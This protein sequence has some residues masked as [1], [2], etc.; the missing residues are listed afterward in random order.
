MS[1]ESSTAQD[2]LIRAE[3]E[4]VLARNVGIQPSEAEIQ[5]LTRNVPAYQRAMLRVRHLPLQHEEAATPPTG[6]PRP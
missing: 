2:P 5:L 6:E 4:R 1:Q 3:I